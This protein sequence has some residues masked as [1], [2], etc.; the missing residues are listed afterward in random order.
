MILKEQNN[1]KKTLTDGIID[2][3]HEQENAPSTNGKARPWLF[4]S[5]VSGFV[6]PCGAVG[7]QWQGLCPLTNA[8]VPMMVP[9]FLEYAK[10]GAIWLFFSEIF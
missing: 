6:L 9:V 7:E 5:G 8:Q 3:N 2:G 4:F 1:Q 10:E